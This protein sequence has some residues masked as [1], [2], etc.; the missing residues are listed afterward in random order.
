V[1]DIAQQL[2]RL[3]KDEELRR[4]LI[5]K[6][7]KRAASLTFDACAEQTAKVIQ[8]LLYPLR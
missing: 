8:N 2:L 3:A 1:E 5:A 7:K 6:G 4:S